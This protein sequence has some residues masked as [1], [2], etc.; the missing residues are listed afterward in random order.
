MFIRNGD[1][2][3]E[4][5]T[6]QVLSRRHRRVYVCWL[7]RVQVSTCAAAATTVLLN[8]LGIGA[9]QLPA[10]LELYGCWLGADVGRLAADGVCF[11]GDSRVQRFVVKRLLRLELRRGSDW[12]IR[13]GAVV[14]ITNQ[15]WRDFFHAEYFP[16]LDEAARN[17]TFA[18]LFAARLARATRGHYDAVSSDAGSL[19]RREHIAGA[20]WCAHW[21]WQLSRNALRCVVAGLHASGGCAG[22][23]RAANCDCERAL[24]R[25]V[26]ACAAARWLC[27][28]RGAAC[29]PRHSGRC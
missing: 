11:D 14:V 24:P 9:R 8:M 13:A 2:V 4:K 27:C 17:V 28:T 25:R 5:R 19:L 29:A 7:V 15:R 3:F 10:F 12:H 22:C 26:D 1:D 21:V 18:S 6:A 16:L 23:R 20:K